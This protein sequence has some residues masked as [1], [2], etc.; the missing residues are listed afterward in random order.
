MLI[1]PIE[2]S[3]PWCGEANTVML[4]LTDASE[5]FVED[6][7]VCCSPIVYTVQSSIES[8]SPV[9]SCSRENG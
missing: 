6:C 8:D 4:D 1:E 3:C 5:E 7:Q 9:L 2:M